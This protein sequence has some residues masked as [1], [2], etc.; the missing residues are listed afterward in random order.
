MGFK[1]TFISNVADYFDS[2]SIHGF[3][4]L[5]KSQNLIER[6]VWIVIIG[7]CFF[8]AGYMINQSLIEYDEN[9]ILTTFERYFGYF[10]K[11]DVIYKVK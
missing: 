5:R 2:T 4:Y 10:L 3:A 8:T 1:E 11:Y 6:L 9:P 7:V